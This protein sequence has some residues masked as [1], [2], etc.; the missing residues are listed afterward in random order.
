MRQVKVAALQPRYMFIPGEYSP[1]SGSLRS[2]VRAIIENYVK[3]QIATTAGL[4]EK[5]GASGCGI[6]C[7]CEDTTT[8]ADFALDITETGVFP[9]L[10]EAAQPLAEAC[11]SAAAQKYSMYVIG[12]HL[13]KLGGKIYNTAS[14]FDRKG[15]IA[16][17]YRK[18]QL[19]ANETWQVAGG[20]SLDVF[21][22]DFGK[23][24]IS[25]CYDMMFP[26]T[27]QILALKGAEIIFH[28]TAGYGW[29]DS[30]GEAALRTRANDNG[31]Y[32]VTAKNYVFNAAGKSSVIDFWGHVLVD[33]GF[34]ENAIASAEIDLDIKKTHPDYYI[35]TYMSGTS[36]VPERMRKERRTELFMAEY[37]ALK[38]KLIEEQYAP[39]G[40]ERKL[41]ILEAMRKWECH[42]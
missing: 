24:G 2:D 5:A 41:Q 39:P 37:E 3:P 22:L 34:A 29:N 6:V 18:T 25:I 14:I 36:D 40:R 42:W 20:D 21:E 32:I 19:P 17:R 28:P 38:N 10:V 23:I 15:N 1:F 11:F 13:A 12:C 26:E 30:I 4:L 9:Q 8:L 35:N 7:A 27:V 16:G 31:V 33:A